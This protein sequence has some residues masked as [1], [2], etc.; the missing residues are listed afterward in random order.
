MMERESS[1]S[2]E[3][4]SAPALRLAAKPA[5]PGDQQ[6][7]RRPWPGRCQP[8]AIRRARVRG[9]LVRR[10]ISPQGIEPARGRSVGVEQARAGAVIAHEIERGAL[11][12]VTVVMVSPAFSGVAV[13][14]VRQSARDAPEHRGSERWQ[15]HAGTGDPRRLRAAA[16]VAVRVPLDFR[17]QD[18]EH[19]EAEVE[20]LRKRF[21][22]YHAAH[23]A[24][25]QQEGICSPPHPTPHPA[26][27][28]IK[29]RTRPS[30]RSKWHFRLSLTRVR[31]LRL[32]GL[33]AY[34]PRQCNFSSKGHLAAT[35]FPAVLF[36][37]VAGI[38]Q[39]S[40]RVDPAPQ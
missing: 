38:Y 15:R 35:A 10:R 24:L 22:N 11:S 39:A 31:G 16:A 8:A 19:W 36:C 29:C 14:A 18:R 6:R 20:K 26:T 25:F 9:R 7:P 5:E 37:C 4:A 13:G 17:N 40:I 2:S 3:A 28:S 33:T 21:C 23:R 12:P 34:G 32:M 27:T 1:S 30:N